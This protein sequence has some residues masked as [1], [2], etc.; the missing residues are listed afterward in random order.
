M[1]HEVRTKRK[2]VLILWNVLAHNLGW[3]YPEKISRLT[4][5][6]TF[7]HYH[8]KIFI[9]FD[10]LKLSYLPLGSSHPSGHLLSLVHTTGCGSSTN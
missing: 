1:Q 10:N 9:D 2:D 5:E 7:D 3:S 6:S 4:R 8:V